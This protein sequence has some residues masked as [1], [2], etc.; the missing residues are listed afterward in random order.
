[1]W[2]IIVCASNMFRWLLHAYLYLLCRY[3]HLLIVL[4]KHANEK[5]WYG[6]TAWSRSIIRT[7][8]VVISVAMFTK[9]D[10]YDDYCSVSFV[11]CTE[12]MLSWH[13]THHCQL[14]HRI[15]Y[16]VGSLFWSVIFCQSDQWWEVEL[17]IEEIHISMSLRS[18]I[19]MVKNSNEFGN[20]IWKLWV[21]MS[22]RT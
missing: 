15:M 2:I 3:L 5:G 1:M 19:F 18:T 16:C 20:Y 22:G 10:R 9:A 17:S 4:L 12:E 8:F 7:E 13:G 21:M 6:L 14:M 11:Y